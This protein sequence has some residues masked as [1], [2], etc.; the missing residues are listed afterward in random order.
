MSLMS[1]KHLDHCTDQLRQALMCNADLS[2]V[3]LQWEPGAQRNRAVVASTHTCRNFE[4][5]Q[6]WAEEHRLV[7][8]DDSVNM[9]DPLKEK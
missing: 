2:T 3:W 7:T 5:I 9:E 1:H 6:Q 8:W 4:K